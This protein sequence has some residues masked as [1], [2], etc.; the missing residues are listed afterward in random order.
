MPYKNANESQQF[1]AFVS[2][3]TI[4]SV[5][6][7]FLKNQGYEFEHLQIPFMTT[8]LNPYFPGVMAMYGP[9]KPVKV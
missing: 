6:F 5:F 4:N 3:Y 9:G 1:Q 7:T 2:N 8:E